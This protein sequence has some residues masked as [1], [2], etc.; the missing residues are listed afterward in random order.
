MSV[1]SELA[2]HWLKGFCGGGVGHQVT[3]GLQHWRRSQVLYYLYRWL[4]YLIYSL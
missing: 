2:P 1:G 4:K 3:D